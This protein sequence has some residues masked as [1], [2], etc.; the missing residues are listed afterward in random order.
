M[1]ACS[2]ADSMSASEASSSAVAIFV[3]FG[4]KIVAEGGH[5]LVQF[6]GA[7][8]ALF[9]GVVGVL[10]GFQ[11]GGFISLEGLDFVAG[12]ELQIIQ[13]AVIGGVHH[14][15][16]E[17]SSAT[18]EGQDLVLPCD[19]DG[20]RFHDLGVDHIVCRI[21]RRVL[22]TFRWSRQSLSSGISLGRRTDP[23]THRPAPRASA[24]LAHLGCPSGEDRWAYAFPAEALIAE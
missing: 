24:G 8:G 12:D 10:D 16:L 9:G 3:F 14:R 22:S 11:N 7:V 18:P 6:L 2:A 4:V 13:S 15:D 5:R 21:K 20:D 19:L 1:G 23:H 17:R